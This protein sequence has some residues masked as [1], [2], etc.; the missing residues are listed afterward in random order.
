M[1][2]AGV[3]LPYQAEAVSVVESSRVTVWEKSRRIG[4]TWGIA[5]LAV[6][7]SAKSETQGGMDTLYIGFS[8]ALAREFIDAAAEWAKQFLQVAASVDEVMFNDGDKDIQ[9]F[10]ICFASGFEIVALTSKPR[11]LRGRQGFVIIDEAAF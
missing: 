10:R 1:T 3:L 8:H 7:T 9:A 6:L 11:S 4:A 2:P 5:A